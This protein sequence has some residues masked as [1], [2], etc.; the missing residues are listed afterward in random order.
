MTRTISEQ[1]GQVAV[2]SLAISSSWK[3]GFVQGE[4]QDKCKHNLKYHT[5]WIFGSDP[6]KDTGNSTSHPLRRTQSPRSPLRHGRHSSWYHSYTQANNNGGNSSGQITV[7]VNEFP[8]TSI[9]VFVNKLELIRWC[10]AGGD[11]SYVSRWTRGCKTWSDRWAA[12]R[13]N[14]GGTRNGFMTS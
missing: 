2:S 12:R 4:S 5:P 1:L 11:C 6:R 10:P 8:E 13:I 3:S 14:W 7:D 9:C